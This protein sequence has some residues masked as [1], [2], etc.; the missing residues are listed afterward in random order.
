MKDKYKRT[1]H[2]CDKV[3]FIN[4]HY[5]VNYPGKYCNRTCYF[6]A[7]KGVR[8]SPKT[9][10]KKGQ[11]EWG[12]HINFKTG[13][14]SYQ[15]F[16][17]GYC[18]DCKTDGDLQVHHLDK[19]RHNNKLENLRT[20]CRTCHWGYH[21]GKRAPAWNKGIKMKPLSQEH[22]DKIRKGVKKHYATN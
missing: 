6:K 14:W 16:N 7:R 21:R 19:N 1:C 17:K 5:G 11:S 3:Y 12:K 2:Q 9:E 18:E 4:P 10:F 8:V 15:K 13:I 20:L 22:K